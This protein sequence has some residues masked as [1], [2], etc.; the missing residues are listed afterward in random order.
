MSIQIPLRGTLQ[1]LDDSKIC[2]WISTE[3]GELEITEAPTMNEHRFNPSFAQQAGK[4]VYAAGGK[5]KQ[6]QALVSVERLDVINKKWTVLPA[7]MNTPRHSHSSCT[8]SNALYVFCGFAK[9]KHLDSI[10]VLKTNVPL[11]EQIWYQFPKFPSLQPKR[12]VSVGALNDCEIVLMGGYKNGSLQ[13]D[14]H[15]FNSRTYE[16]KKI[17]L[18]EPFAFDCMKNQTQ[19]TPGGDSIVSLVIAKDDQEHVIRYTKGDSKV[20]ILQADFDKCLENR[21]PEQTRIDLIQAQKYVSLE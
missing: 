4:W 9:E 6:G 12:N 18:S 14:I 2:R 15:I 21:Q 3:K 10:E 19:T 13:D 5:D 7:K 16:C 17:E 1:F 8:L 20:Q 11:K